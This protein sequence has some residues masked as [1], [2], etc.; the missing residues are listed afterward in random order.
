[1]AGTQYSLDMPFRF[2]YFQVI[3]NPDSLIDIMLEIKAAYKILHNRAY[4]SRFRFKVNYEIHSFNKLII[5]Y[6]IS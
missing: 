5:S 6:L 4:N 2:L 1:M 3:A